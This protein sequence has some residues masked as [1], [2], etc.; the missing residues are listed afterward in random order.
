[1]ESDEIDNALLSGL[2]SAAWLYVWLGL[3]V[4]VFFSTLVPG[5]ALSLTMVV[6]FGYRLWGATFSKIHNAHTASIKIALRNL[7]AHEFMRAGEAAT[8]DEALTKA[9][10]STGDQAQAFNFRAATIA[11]A[12]RLVGRVIGCAIELAWVAGCAFA[13]LRFGSTVAGYLN[14]AVR[15][16]T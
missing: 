4:F 15:L 9:D 8:L 6:V 3:A 7:A 10:R 2:L 14:Q 11:V 5:V 16:A 12:E 1:M 13:G